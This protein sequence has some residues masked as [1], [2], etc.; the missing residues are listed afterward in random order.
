[1]EPGGLPQY[2]ASLEHF[3]TAMAMISSPRH[4]NNLNFGTVTEIYLVQHICK[5][6]EYIEARNRT[7]W[8]CSK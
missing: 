3:T 5:N 1:M 8:K 7:A 4:V 6:I 2:E